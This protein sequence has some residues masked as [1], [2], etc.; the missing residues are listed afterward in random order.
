MEYDETFMRPFDSHNLTTVNPDALWKES[1]LKAIEANICSMLEHI[2]LAFQVSSYDTRTI[3]EYLTQ[4]VIKVRL[5][6]QG[7]QTIRNVRVYEH[8]ITPLLEKWYF[9]VGNTGIRPIV[10]YKKLKLSRGEMCIIRFQ[11]SE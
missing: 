4:T 1:F 8:D 6:R 2:L 9:V 10:S 11:V 5:P 3:S 7:G